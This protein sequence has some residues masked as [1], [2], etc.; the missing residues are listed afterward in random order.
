M[1]KEEK[2][3]LLNEAFESYRGFIVR[4][5]PYDA[6][7]EFMINLLP[8]Q[9]LIALLDRSPNQISRFKGGKA[10]PGTADRRA[11]YKFYRE[12]S[13]AP[14]PDKVVNELYGED[15]QTT[16]LFTSKDVKESLDETRKA[17]DQMEVLLKSAKRSML[18][19]LRTIRDNA[20]EAVAA[21]TDH[22]DQTNQIE[23]AE[24]Q[25]REESEKDDQKTDEM[26]GI[27]E[28]AK[29]YQVHHAKDKN[30]NALISTDRRTWFYAPF[31]DGRVG[32]TEE[33]LPEVLGLFSDESRDVY[34][35]LQMSERILL[36]TLS[37]AE[38][39]EPD[40]DK[41]AGNPKRFWEF[42]GKFGKDNTERRRTRGMEVLNDIRRS[43]WSLGQ[44]EGPMTDLTE[45]QTFAARMTRYYVKHQKELLFSGIDFEHDYDTMKVNEIID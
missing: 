10:E 17:F 15:V 19:K 16:P 22:S 27:E 6:A 39:D 2:Q 28:P 23:Q 36:E 26:Q 30:G 38:P 3:A 24:E 18:R 34:D 5:L 8:N 42:Y 31:V 43:N 12:I 9:A 25:P 20:P 35:K 45:I 11:L 7:C 13:E 41:L 1:D 44:I 37:L 21:Q 40:L 4:N 14:L 29:P 33:E 32:Y